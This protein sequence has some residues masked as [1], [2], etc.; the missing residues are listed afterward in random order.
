MESDACVRC[1]RDG[2]CCD[3]QEL[4]GTGYNHPVV[5]LQVRATHC[6]VA[7]ITSQ[8]PKSRSLSRRIPI[9]QIPPPFDALDLDASPELY[10]ETGIMEK[11]S[12]IVIEHIFSIPLSMLRSKSYKHN[13]CAFDTRLRQESYIRLIER[14]GINIEGEEWVETL[15]LALRSA[16]RGRRQRV[17][18]RDPW[19]E[20]RGHTSLPSTRRNRGSPRR[21]LDRRSYSEPTPS[22]TI[23]AL[24]PP[25]R[26][27]TQ[28]RTAIPRS[29]R[30]EWYTYDRATARSILRSLAVERTLLQNPSPL[31]LP[32]PS[33]PSPHY[34][35]PVQTAW[36]PHPHPQTPSRP[37]R[38]TYQTVLPSV[39]RYDRAHWDARIQDTNSRNDDLERGGHGGEDDQGDCDGRV[40]AQL[41]MLFLGVGALFLW[42]YRG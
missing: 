10:L 2:D 24:P 42:F 31:P 41:V 20:M 28:T 11:Q 30:F 29:P 23:P 33:S 12:Y 40:F 34:L 39:E 25:R 3:G 22:T 37:P 19:E 36:R 13:S 16:D 17:T 7:K 27:P 18:F 6:S 35:A 32:L 14:F 5:I 26:T 38:S 1:V 9:S 8:P 15:V 21:S 4:E